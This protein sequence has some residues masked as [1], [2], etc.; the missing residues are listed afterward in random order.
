MYTYPHAILLE[1]CFVH[2]ALRK[3][4]WCDA[5]RLCPTTW[6]YADIADYVSRLVRGNGALVPVY[7]MKA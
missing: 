4:L 2:Q 5:L 6:A 7:A 3:R 1:M